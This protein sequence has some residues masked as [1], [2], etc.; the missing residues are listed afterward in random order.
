M[1]AVAIATVVAH[2]GIVLTIL[3]ISSVAILKMIK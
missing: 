3:T 1:D 2:Y